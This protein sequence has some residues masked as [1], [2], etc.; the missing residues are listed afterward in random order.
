MIKKFSDFSSTEKKARHAAG[1]AI[2]HED[3]ILLVHPTGGS[4]TRPIMGIPKGGIEEGEDLMDAAIREV[5]EETGIR[6]SPPQL[7]TRVE[8]VDIFNNAGKYRHSLYY[9]ICRISDLTEIGLTSK[10]V[11]KSQLQIEEIDWA[12]FVNIREAY[13]K[14]AKSQLIILDR[15]S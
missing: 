9:F 11:P 3:Q 5:F 6:L 8:T 10:S 12:G 7:D 14:T 2:I 13:S 1:V 4:W 15:L